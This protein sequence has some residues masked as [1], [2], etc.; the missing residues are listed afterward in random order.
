M[1]F[2]RSRCGLSHSSAVVEMAS[3]PMNA[4]NTAATP[5]STPVILFGMNGVQLFGFT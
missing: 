1:A 4:Q 2:G 3:N 5:L